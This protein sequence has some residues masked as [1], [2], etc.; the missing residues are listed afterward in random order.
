MSLRTPL[1]ANAYY[2]GAPRASSAMMDHD[3][4][5]T[6]RQARLTLAGL[7]I[8]GVIGVLLFGGWIP[9]LHPN[10]TPSPYATVDGRTYYWTATNVPIPTP[11]ATRTL[12]SSE[13]FRNV[14]FTTW[15]TNWS[16]LGGTYL[17]VKA[18]EANGTSY[19]FALGGYEVAANW[20]DQYIAPDGTVAAEWSGGLSA[21]L[22]VLP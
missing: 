22:F 13:Q 12:P 3:F 2:L 8:G 4:P 17:H 6:P 14:T 5:P 16:L 19:Q 18:M 20:T 15:V 10:F 1:E 11:G 7:A 9:G 21:Y